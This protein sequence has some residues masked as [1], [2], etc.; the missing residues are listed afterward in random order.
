[1]ERYSTCV[2]NVNLQLYFKIVANGKHYC[3]SSP[4]RY[5][6]PC[7]FCDSFCWQI[8]DCLIVFERQEE[9]VSNCDAV[10][11][12]LKRNGERSRKGAACPEVEDALRQS[13]RYCNLL[14]QPSSAFPKLFLS[15]KLGS[16]M[17]LWPYWAC[18]N[19]AQ[20]NSTKRQHLLWVYPTERTETRWHFLICLFAI[21]SWFCYVAGIA[22]AFKNNRSLYLFR[23]LDW[24]CE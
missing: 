13:R 4:L 20:G 8:S 19:T 12:G 10:D 24:F 1:M 15:V 5:L 23:K 3:N 18:A 16:L 14:N 17:L 7:L 9:H 2:E 6:N 21:F 22:T 11:F